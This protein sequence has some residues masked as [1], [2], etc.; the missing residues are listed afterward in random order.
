[1]EILKLCVI[2]AI[3]IIVLRMKKPLSLAMGIGCICLVPLYRIELSKAFVILFDTVTSWKTLQLLLNIYL[4][5]FLQRMMDKRHH[6][7]LAQKSLCGLFNNRRVNASA[8]PIFIGLLPSPGAIFIAGSMVESSVGDH[9]TSDEKTFVASYFRHIS[10][11]FMPTYTGIILAC[12]LSGIAAGPFVVGMLPMVAVL[13]ALG[14]FFYLRKIPKETGL[15]PSLDKKQDAKNLVW[16]LWSIFT[17]IL[18]IIFLKFKVY[19]ATGLI[20]FIYFLVNKFTFSEVKPFI[21]SA[22]EP[23]IMINTVVVML[24]KNLMTATGIV[25]MLPSLFEKLPIPPYMAFC[26]IFFFGTLVAG[27]QAI[28][29]L[30]LPMAFAAIPGAGLPLMCF[31]MC[32]T[33]AAMQI[34]PTHLCLHLA[35]EYFHTDY[36]RLVKTTLPVISVFYIILL[37]YYNVW[38]TLV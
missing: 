29:A 7:E 34:S 38:V 23:K 31:L 15:P 18:L 2:F 1:M 33:Y 5:T 11:A 32:A 3:I 24:F 4:I 8:A 37:I 16:S 36:S 30:C 28:I 12:Q 14:Y 25:D 9:L 6:I 26:I 27:S 20:L 22:F 21:S 13:I 19:T 17:I 35:C 10:E